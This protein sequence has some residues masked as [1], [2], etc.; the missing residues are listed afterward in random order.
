M[1]EGFQSPS[2]FAS[3]CSSKI[4]DKTLADFGEGKAGRSLSVIE[5]S[6]V[7]YILSALAK[8]YIH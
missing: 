2:L 1:W 7:F 4:G 8:Q 5:N 3:L 6:F